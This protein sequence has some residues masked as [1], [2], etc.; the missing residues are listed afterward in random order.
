MFKSL[1][2]KIV[3]GISLFSFLIISVTYSI[4]YFVNSNNSINFSKE[5]LATEVAVSLSYLKKDESS[6]NDVLQALVSSDKDIQKLVLISK[7]GKV[8]EIKGASFKDEVLFFESYKINNYDLTIYYSEKSKDAYMKALVM[9][10]LVVAIAYGLIFFF[11][12]LIVSKHLGPA[13]Q[14]V[15]FFEK[16]DINDIKKLTYKTKKP[17]LEFLQIK[18][19][20]NNMLEILEKYAKEIQK[21]AYIDGL[22]ELPNRISFKKEIDKRIEEKQQFALLFLD[23][24]GFKLINDTMGH[25]M[26][27]LLLKH[28]GDKLS[29]FSSKSK[30]FRFGG[31]EF[32]SIIEFSNEIE[33]KY[34][35]EKI[36]ESVKEDVVIDSKNISIT[37]SI[38]AAL[39]PQDSTNDEDLVKFADIAMYRAKEKGK[40]KII[41]FN[42]EM[43]EK[44]EKEVRLEE[45]IKNAAIREEFVLVFQPQKDLDTGKTISAESLIRWNHPEKGLLTPYYF[46][47]FL[48][49]SHYIIP[50][51]FQ[52]I[53]QSCLFIVEMRK[54]GLEKISINVATK[55]IEDPIFLRNFK[56]IL[57]ETACKPE[58]IELEITE[59]TIVSNL[60]QIKDTLEML[61]SMGVSIAID[62]F[63]TGESSLSIL[64]ELPIDKLKI[65]KSFIDKLDHQSFLTL[66]IID[67]ANNM[68]I[69]VIAEG[70]ETKEQEFFLKNNN[71]HEIQ[72]YLFAKPMDKDSLEKFL[73]KDL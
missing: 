25:K 53:K 16:F 51:G 60:V 44:I 37:T 2:A 10:M 55:Q 24:D 11:M 46:I 43:L 48:E 17:S 20:I 41:F 62:D 45:E 61:R 63:G 14:I 66:S 59:R 42:K 5:K 52:V 50:V 15:E 18:N 7:D 21:L 31:D 6:I 12:S 68:G 33:L 4:L 13:S 71:C 26:G 27:D 72:G 58:W 57:R 3:G 29:S 47:D 70:V 19:S 56:R 69:K 54:L 8:K 36:I 67:I 38:G 9:R 39:Y 22:T 1:K 32:V 23:L 49:S 64:G 34:L 65:D 28:I 35:C 40:N 73:N 30:M